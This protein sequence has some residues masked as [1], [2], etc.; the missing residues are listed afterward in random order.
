MRLSQLIFLISSTIASRDYRVELRVT[1]LRRSLRLPAPNVRKPRRNA[2]ATEG[3]IVN[4]ARPI[5]QCRPQTAAE[6][7]AIRQRR[8]CHERSG[9]RY[10]QAAPMEPDPDFVFLTTLL[11][12]T[13]GRTE[14]QHQL[15]LRIESQVRHFHGDRQPLAASRE[16]LARLVNADPKV[17]P[18]ANTGV[19]TVLRP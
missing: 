13:P 19:N 1:W 14:K 8:F 17:C 2:P 12:G 11:R 10:R 6:R 7:R 3:K 16:R 18:N 9:S 15:R 4:G 5:R